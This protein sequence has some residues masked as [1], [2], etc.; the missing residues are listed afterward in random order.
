DQLA[1]LRGVRSVEND[2]FLSEVYTGLPRTSGRRPAFGSV[3]SR[4]APNQS[5]LPTYVSLDRAT[6]DQFEY[7]KPYYA[8]SGHAPFRPFGD[9]LQDLTPVRSLEQLRD[10]RTL[11]TAFDAMRRDLD[12]GGTLAGMDRFHAQAL[13][14]IT[15][16]RVRDAFD[17]SK[18]PER[19][20]AAYG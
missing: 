19:V 1:L 15:S 3:V 10:R 18:E 8:G 2:H 20:V 9:A 16:P 12:A 7:E 5:A 14:I 6:T 13:N 4:L 17:L 11:L